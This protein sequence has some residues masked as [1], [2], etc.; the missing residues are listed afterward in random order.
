[1]KISFTRSTMIWWWNDAGVSEMKRAE[2]SY[3]WPVLNA[4][5]FGDEGADCTVT[6]TPSAGVSLFLLN[7]HP[8][9]G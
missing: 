3:Q 1:M 8:P 2:P 4:L 5:G 6:V 7:Q 9:S